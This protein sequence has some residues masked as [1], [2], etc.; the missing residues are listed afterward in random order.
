M[1]QKKDGSR[2]VR[3]VAESLGF[4]IDWDQQNRAVLLTMERLPS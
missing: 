1:G 3:H 2:T 4:E